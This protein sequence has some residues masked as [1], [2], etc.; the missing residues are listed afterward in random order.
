MLL[1]FGFVVI[2]MITGVARMA[3]YCF[4]ELCPR[5]LYSSSEASKSS[6]MQH[7]V[8]NRQ[9]QISHLPVEVQRD[10]STYDRTRN[11]CSA[12][13]IAHIGACTVRGGEAV[14]FKRKGG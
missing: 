11:E 3:Q 14:L 10:E 1:R 13:I 6:C 12:M 8:Y 5:I 9:G 4:D 2:S 7:R